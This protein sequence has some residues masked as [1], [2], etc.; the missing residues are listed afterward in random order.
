MRAELASRPKTAAF[1]RLRQRQL[2]YK[3]MGYSLG[4]DDDDD[5]DNND[6]DEG[7]NKDDGDDVSVGSGNADKTVS[8]YDTSAAHALVASYFRSI[9]S[10]SQMI[11]SN[12]DATE[13]IATHAHLRHIFATCLSQNKLI[14]STNDKIKSRRYIERCCECGDCCQQ[15]AG[16]ES[17]EGGGGDGGG[18]SGAGGCGGCSDGIKPA[19]HGGGG[20]GG[21][22]DAHSKE[23]GR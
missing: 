19:C 12:R 22:G 6:D 4:D 5:D 20:G 9:S 11:K 13:N 23:I 2:T 1:A 21:G 10:L 3:A 7:D 17:E 15:A 18:D 8:H 14:T 16:G